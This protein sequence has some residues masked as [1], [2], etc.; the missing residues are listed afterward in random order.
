[1][2]TGFNKS[3]FEAAIRAAARKQQ[4]EIDRVN[5]EN[6]RR[7]EAY[8]REASRVNARNR[9]AAQRQLDAHNR[10]IERV[11]AHNR[12]VNQRNQRANEQNRTA[13][14][15]LNRQLRSVSSSGPSYTPAEQTLADRIQAQVVL[16]PDRDLDAFLSYARSD[17]SEVGVALRDALEAL[18]VAVWFDEIAIVPGR[19]QSLQMDRGLRTA[20]C[21]ITLLTQAYL[22]GRFWTERELGAL[23]HKATL[24]PVL[25]NVTFE[26][27]AE[28]S[29]I[30]PDLAGFETSRDCVEVIAEKIAA[31]V[32]PA[33]PS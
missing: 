24:I 7:V 3:Q 4:A 5:R 20:R 19:S 33:E 2:A 6:K 21:G 12:Q 11:N 14:A 25:H 26:E 8:N 28:Y 27:V 18:G 29:G 17:G 31:A 22:T 1:M 13:V 15:N 30:L 23:L 10:E 9:Q 16:H 32:L